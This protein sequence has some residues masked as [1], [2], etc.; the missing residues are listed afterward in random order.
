MT[1]TNVSSLKQGSVLSRFMAGFR[2]PLAGLRHLVGNPRLWPYVVVP[3]FLT[4]LMIG[5]AAWL[6]WTQGP[7]AL[8]LAWSQ[9]TGEGAAGSVALIAWNIA[10]VVIRL[11]L[12]VLGAVAFY[13]IGGLVAIPFNDFLSQAVEESLLGGRNEPFT[14]GLFISDIRMSL[15]HSLLG[16]FLYVAVMIPVLLLNVIPVA[17]SVASTVL[18]WSATVVFLARE[19]LDGPLSRDRLPFGVK[20]TVLKSNKATMA[21]FGSATAAMLWVPGLNLFSIPCA[22]VGGTLLY[23]QLKREGSLP[24]PRKRV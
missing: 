15:G 7:A 13:A 6:A 4:I 22:V 21:G 18:G 19:M 1:S 10:L 14:W 17:G 11:L 5:G 23:C 9:P 20:L 24:E 8:E 2:Y 3:V 16:L 12:F